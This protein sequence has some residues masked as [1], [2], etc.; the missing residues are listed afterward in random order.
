MQYWNTFWISRQRV[1]GCL[2]VMRRG[3]KIHTHVW[4]YVLLFRKGNNQS[5]E[6]NLFLFCHSQRFLQTLKCYANYEKYWRNTF[7]LITAIFYVHMVQMALA[8][9]FD[10]IRQNLK[11]LV[12]ILYVK[13]C[14]RGMTKVLPILV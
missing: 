9:I 2:R 7:L 12:E 8:L 1:Q 4:V 3:L 14:S 13:A 6:K 11:L 5:M 10:K